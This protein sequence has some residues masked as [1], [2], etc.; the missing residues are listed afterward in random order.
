MVR[1]ALLYA[2]SIFL[3]VLPSAAFAQALQPGM[4]DTIVSTFLAQAQSWQATLQ[5]IALGIFHPLLVIE[6]AWTLGRAF[7]AD[8]AFG[9]ILLLLGMQAIAAGFFYWLIIN[10][11]F[12]Y[13]VVHG[14]WL[15]GSMASGSAVITPSD[16]V[17]AALAVGSTVWKSLTWGTIMSAPILAV[18]LAIVGLI[19]VVLFGFMAATL[20][21]TLIEAAIVSYAGVVL[22]GLGGLS[23][24]RDFAIGMY[25]WALSVGI[26]LMVL[27]L[28]MGVAANMMKQFASQ[29]G[30]ANVATMTWQDAGLLLIFPIIMWRL[31]ERIPGIA[32][33]MIAGSHVEYFGGYAQTA[34]RLAAAGAGAAAA[35]TSAGV[36]IAAAGRLAAAQIGAETAAAGGGAAA[37]GIS[38]AALITGRTASNMAR[39]AA[40]DVANRASGMPGASLGRFGGR[41]AR[42]MDQKTTEIKNRT[43]PP[44]GRP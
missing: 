35:I 19:V 42:N 36:S 43:P 18:L 44:G 41:M 13:D 21:E 40:N 28:I 31:S 33:G 24:T 27:Q 4:L 5:Q 8:L 30:G 23:Y 17:S 1:K 11:I 12:L 3:L 2:A 10:P 26:K 22:L 20:V 6:V 16:T 9:E 7:V 25:R 38:Q 32:Q 37:G 34:T 39:A 29:I 15:A 14:F